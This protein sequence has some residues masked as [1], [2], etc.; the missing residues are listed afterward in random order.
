M[1]QIDLIN[2]RYK[3]TRIL[4]AEPDYAALQAVDIESR[5]KTEYLLNVY[6]GALGRH[7]ADCF[8]RLQ[9][10]PEYI[11]MFLTGGAL[12]AVFKL[13]TFAD[14]DSYFFKG[15]DIPPETRVG[16]AQE[17]FHLALCVFDFPPEISCAV[18]YSRNL[19]MQPADAALTANYMIAPLSGLRAGPNNREF[20][21]LLYDQV[22][23]IFLLRFTSENAECELLEDIRVMLA[24]GGNISMSA[25]YVHWLGAREKIL[26]QIKITAEMNPVERFGHF[27][28][29]YLK[30]CYRRFAQKVSNNE[31][32]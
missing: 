12:V 1:A 10:C 14:I 8:D 32:T 15:A 13:N 29:L 17:L 3:V 11:D 24:Q 31:L 22:K 25:L 26:E 6:E 4:Y 2:S 21:Y 9:Y 7:Y 5:E 30:R 19:R 28:F 18:L 23:K 16:Y 20:F 27:A